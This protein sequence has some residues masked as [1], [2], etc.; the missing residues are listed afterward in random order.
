MIN[1]LATGSGRKKL[2]IVSLIVII[3]GPIID[4]AII[5]PIYGC[6]GKNS[7]SGTCSNAS[8]RF[9]QIVTS[10]IHWLTYAAVAMLIVVLV[11]WLVEKSKKKS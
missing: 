2:L 9:D 4:L 11:A 8:L 10:V 3:G 6:A 5:F 1:P 7:T